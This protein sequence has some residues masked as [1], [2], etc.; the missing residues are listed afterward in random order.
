MNKLWKKLMAAVCCTT[1]VIGLSACGAKDS[2]AADKGSQAAEDAGK[3]SMAENTGG[4]P[5]DRARNLSHCNGTGNPEDN[6][7]VKA[8][9]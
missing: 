9:Y 5:A 3:E 4:F 2:P 8:L 7:Y 1:L 6:D